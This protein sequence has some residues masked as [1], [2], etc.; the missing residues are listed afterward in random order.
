MT[1]FTL[2]LGDDFL[3]LPKLTSDGRNWVIYKDRLMLSVQAC[4]LGGNLDRT[5]TKPTEPAVTQG[6]ANRELTEEEEEK[7]NMYKD[8]LKEWLQKKAIVSQQVVS[9]ILYLLYLKIRESQQL[10][11]HGITQI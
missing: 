4:G 8:N 11:K 9:T 2:K 1:S 10:K 3:R 5:T 6:L 7:I